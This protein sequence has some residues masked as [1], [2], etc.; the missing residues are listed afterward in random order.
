MWATL[1]GRSAG[2]KLLRGPFAM[3]EQ[4]LQ[5]AWKY[6][7]VWRYN[8]S[9]QYLHSSLRDLGLG[10]TSSRWTHLRM[11]KR[12]HIWLFTMP[13]YRFQFSF[14]SSSFT[15]GYV[16]WPLWCLPGSCWGAFTI[17]PLG[18][19]AEAS[20]GGCP[21]WLQLLSARKHCP[22]DWS[23]RRCLWRCH[24]GVPGP[25]S[26]HTAIQPLRLQTVTGDWEKPRE[27][28]MCLI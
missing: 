1:G 9:K 19:G 16:G 11:W 22:L 28:R 23:W 14:F 4:Y 2:V 7:N 15:Q 13:F 27:S 8:R 25:V 26:R 18:P 17:Q 12:P 10:K 3:L 24:Q 20:R 21:G 6:C 5:S